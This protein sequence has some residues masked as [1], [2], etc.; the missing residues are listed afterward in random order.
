MEKNIQI[1]NENGKNKTIFSKGALK[2]KNQW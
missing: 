1:A 2:K